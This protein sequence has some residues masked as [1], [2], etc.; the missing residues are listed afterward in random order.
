ML[1]GGTLTSRGRLRYEGGARAATA[2]SRSAHPAAKVRDPVVVGSIAPPPA[3]SADC[4]NGG[5]ASVRAVWRGRGGTRRRGATVWSSYAPLIMLQLV[6]SAAA[7]ATRTA[8]KVRQVEESAP[9]ISPRRSACSRGSP[10]RGRRGATPGAGGLAAPRPRSCDHEGGQRAADEVRPEP[11]RDYRSSAARKRDRCTRADRHD[12][13]ES[14]PVRNPGMHGRPAD[15]A[16]LAED[17]KKR[18]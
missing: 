15:N 18:G 13:L 6:D 14:R 2:G 9:T 17:Q 12:Q 8:P 4:G 16:A 5:N 1:T 3:S 10:I 11:G 7:R